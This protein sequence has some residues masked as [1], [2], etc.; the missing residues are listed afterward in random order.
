MTPEVIEDIGKCIVL[1]IMFFGA[2]IAFVY[3]GYKGN[4]DDN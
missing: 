2:L 1:P 4:D 3:F